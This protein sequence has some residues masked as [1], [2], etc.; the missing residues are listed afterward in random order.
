MNN[1]DF[2]ELVT[3]NPDLPIV[4]MVDG[5]IVEDPG[6]MWMGS[7]TNALIS[8]IG[9]IGERYYDEREDFKDA[10]Y[11]KYEEELDQRFNYKPCIGTWGKFTDE[12]IKANEEAEAMLEAFLDAKADEYMR[13]AIVI[14]VREPDNK[15]F[16]E[17]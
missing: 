10:Y 9:L 17:A 5:E 14:Y 6:M 8:D 16:K 3:Q 11:S 1:K 2:V 7:I 4:A 15:I 12:V 13:K